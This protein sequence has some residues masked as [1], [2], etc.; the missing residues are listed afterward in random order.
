MS[1]LSPSPKSNVGKEA[2]VEFVLPAYTRIQ[3]DTSVFV[4]PANA[5]IQWR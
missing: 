2:I 3:C 1:M 4:V 5:G